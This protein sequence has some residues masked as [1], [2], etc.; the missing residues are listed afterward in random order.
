MGVYVAGG[1]GGYMLGLRYVPTP[2]R[3]NSSAGSLK[4]RVELIQLILNSET[5]CDYPF[6]GFRTSTYRCHLTPIYYL[7]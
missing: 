1:V 2:V 6:V 7:A 4:K 5:K 3:H